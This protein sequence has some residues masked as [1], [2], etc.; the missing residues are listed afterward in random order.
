MKFESSRPRAVVRARVCK[1][2][3]RGGLVAKDACSPRLPTLQYSS[4]PSRFLTDCISQALVSHPVLPRLTIVTAVIVPV[5][6][7]PSNLA[8]GTSDSEIAPPKQESGRLSTVPFVMDL[9]NLARGFLMGVADTVPGVSGGTVALILGHYDRL[10]AAIRHLDAQAIRLLIGGRWGELTRH[11]DLRFLTALG[12]GVGTGIVTLASLMHWLLHHHMNGTLA[13]FFGLVLAS[14]WV[15]RRSV[16]HWNARHL[17]SVALGGATAVAISFLP[18]SQGDVSLPWLFASAAV[19]ICAMILPGISG[20]FLLL[21]FGVYEPVIGMIKS[22][23]GGLSSPDIVLKLT[24]F[25]LGCLFGLLAFSRLLHYLLRRHH[26]PTMACL[27]GLMLGSVARLWPL[28]LP[29]PETVHLE[30]RYQQFQFVAP[31]DYPGSIL[32]L[33]LLIVAGVAIVIVADALACR[34]TRPPQ[35]SGTDNKSSKTFGNKIDT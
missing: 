19:A 7:D 35:C 15:V 9:I 23:P 26:E 4:L 17:L 31:A 21:L 34:L 24:V 3:K 16:G 8:P 20:A 18:S 1:N 30:P 2:K 13:V 29:T 14:V 32:A 12:L 10:I 33:A 22:L 27:I 28:Q 11:T 25:A 5:E 6:D